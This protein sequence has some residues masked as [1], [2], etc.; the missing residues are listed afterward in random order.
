MADRLKEVNITASTALQLAKNLDVADTS[1]YAELTNLG[2]VCEQ[3]LEERQYE[4][5][6]LVE[7]L[8]VTKGLGRYVKGLVCEYY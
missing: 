5:Q 3:A 6:K 7:A 1:K 2:V 8:I 4:P